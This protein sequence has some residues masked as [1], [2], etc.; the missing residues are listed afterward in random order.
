MWFS[1]RV[2]CYDAH[3]IYDVNPWYDQTGFSQ[4]LRKKKEG[5]VR[6]LST[7]KSG[8]EMQQAWGQFTDM[9]SAN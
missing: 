8:A 4:Q 5:G 3:H 7:C 2:E 1:I 6:V 9:A